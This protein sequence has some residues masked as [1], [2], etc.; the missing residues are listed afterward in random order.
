MELNV[1][2]ENGKQ[3]R[4]LY[5]LWVDSRPAI[6]AGLFLT[7]SVI[8]NLKNWDICQEDKPNMKFLRKETLPPSFFL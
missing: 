4:L 2:L 3:I 8:K 7:T 5:W 1:H 6:L